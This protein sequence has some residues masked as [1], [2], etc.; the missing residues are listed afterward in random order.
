MILAKKVMNMKVVE[1]AKIY[2][3]YFGHFSSDIVVLTLFT[4]FA[5]IRGICKICEQC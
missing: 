3:F 4:N 5:Y 1:L 2:N